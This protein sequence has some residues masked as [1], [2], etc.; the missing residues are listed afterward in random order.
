M[1]L[2]G[3]HGVGGDVAACHSRR[4]TAPLSIPDATVDDLAQRVLALAADGARAMVGL[5]GAP[6]AGKST[7]AA[8]LLAALGPRA[9]LVPMD[10]F[11]LAQARLEALGRADRKGAP[12]TFDAHGYVALLTRLRAR[13][14]HVVHAPTFRRDLEEPVAGAVDVP[15]EVDVVLTEGN[16]L[17]LEAPGWADVRAQLDEVWFVEVDEKTREG[18]LVARHERFGRSHDAA[19]AWAR[20]VDGPNAALV[21]ETR[22]RA[23]LVVGGWAG[24]LPVASPGP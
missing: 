7:L 2:S 4:V 21:R 1:R 11:H 8:A 18:R 16:Y 14:G 17:L 23:D 24:A 6:G 10:G 19:V 9:R 20:D 15:H 3:G 5:T 13:P 12:D 22:G